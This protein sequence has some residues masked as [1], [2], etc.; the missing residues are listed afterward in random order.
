MAEPREKTLITKRSLV[1][2]GARLDWSAVL[3]PP[4]VL[5]QPLPPGGGAEPM[6]V[7]PPPPAPG[8]GGQGGGDGG[9][10]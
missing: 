1:W 6:P 7:V 4:L 5:P 2:A 10:L 9:Q 3:P 8:E